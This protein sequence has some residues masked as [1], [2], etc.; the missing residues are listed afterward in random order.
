MRRCIVPASAFFEWQRQ[1]RG[2][3]QPY[4][5]RRRD[6]ERIGFAGLWES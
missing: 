3:K 5:I 6:G 2:S 1:G 4:L